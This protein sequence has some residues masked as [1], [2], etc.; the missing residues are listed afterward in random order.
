MSRAA[1]S[2]GLLVA[3]LLCLV[4]ACTQPP[5]VELATLPGPTGSEP[6]SYREQVKPVLDHRCVICHACY[7]APCQLLL[8]SYEGLDRGATKQP[9]YQASRLMT[10][11]LTRLEIDAQTTAEWREKNFISVLENSGTEGYGSLLLNMLALGRT[12][13]VTPDARLPDDFPLAIDRELSCAATACCSS[14]TLMPESTASAVRAPTPEILSS[15]RK[16]WRSSS[17]ANP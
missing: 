11:P 12:H 8:S 15:C 3:N 5:P 9:V 6:I 10:A 7:D 13:P 14:A 1:A 4:M 16:T 17:V 2:R